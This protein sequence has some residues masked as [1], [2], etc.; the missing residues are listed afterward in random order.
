MV[1]TGEAFLSNG[2]PAGRLLPETIPK[3]VLS[4]SGASKS[5]LTFLMWAVE[6]PLAEP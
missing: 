5:W 3:S 4:A 2:S 6:P 1:G